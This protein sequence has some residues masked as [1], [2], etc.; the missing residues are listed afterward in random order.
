[1]KK[2]CEENFSFVRLKENNKIL[3]DEN[4]NL[5]KSILDIL[6]YLKEYENREVSREQELQVVLL[7]IEIL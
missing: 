5:K 3:Y 2:K 4:N 6:Y 1:M 7:N